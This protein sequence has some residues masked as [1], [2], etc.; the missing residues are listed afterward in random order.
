[1]LVT[2]APHHFTATEFIHS[3][4]GRF[5]I[6]FCDPLS[7]RLERVYEQDRNLHLFVSESFEIDSASLLRPIMSLFRPTL[8]RATAVLPTSVKTAHPALRYY[9]N[10]LS[11]S[12][13]ALLLHHSL[14]FLSTPA[15]TSSKSRCT[16]GPPR[17]GERSLKLGAKRD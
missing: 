10:F 3:N 14:G 15:H 13:Q 5:A 4:F 17:K 9:P 1:M 11:K 8:S 16:S 6:P 2:I 12:E 7:E